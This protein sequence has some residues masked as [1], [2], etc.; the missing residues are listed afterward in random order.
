[1]PKA[2]NKNFV[3]FVATAKAVAL[4]RGL[5]WHMRTDE[6]GTVNPED[7]WDFEILLG[8][9][10]TFKGKLRQL[11]PWPAA[12]ELMQHNCRG[13]YQNAAQP[14]LLEIETEWHD[15]IKAVAVD[16]VLIKKNHAKTLT[17][18]RI[19]PL[20]I[21]MACCKATEP[22]KINATQVRFALDVAK[23]LAKSHRICLETT[24][25]HVFDL[26]LL[27]DCVPL[28]PIALA[29]EKRSVNTA[30]FGGS[31]REPDEMRHRLEER[32]NAAKLPDERSYWES[33][34]IV[35]TEHPRTFT[36]AIRFAQH[37]L[38]ICQGLRVGES[39]TIPVDWRIERNY[40][41]YS[42]N[43][44]STYGGMDRSLSIRYFA[45]KSRGKREDSRV[46]YEATQPVP[47]IFEE[48]IEETMEFVLRLTGPLR[49]RLK[50]QT[51]TGRLL[52]E[53]A[54]GDLVPVSEIY[55]RLSGDL[56]LYDGV[57]NTDLERRYRET[58]NPTILHEL[59]LTQQRTEEKFRKYLTNFFFQFGTRSSGSGGKSFPARHAD[60]S[61]WTGPVTWIDAF[62][63]IGELEEAIR[64]AMRRK[65]PDTIP[66]ALSGGRSLYPHEQ[67][68]LVPKVPLTEE[69]NGNILDV[70]SYFAI[71]VVNPHDHRCAF[72]HRPMNIFSRYGRTEEDRELTLTKTHGTRHLINSELFRL[73]LADAIITKQFGRRSISQSGVYDH[74]SLAEDLNAI[75]LPEDVKA[76]TPPKA[77]EALKLIKSGRVTG[78]LVDD[79][80]RVQR[81]EGEDAAIDF[82]A[83]EADG[84][85]ATPYGYCINS[86]I[87]DACPTHLECFNGCC[88]LAKSENPEHQSN[89][90]QIERKLTKARDAVVNSPLTS[91][92]R[93]NQLREI[94]RKLANVMK[95]IA[96]A[97]GA[98]IFPDGSDLSDCILNNDD[99]TIQ[100][101]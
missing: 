60:G 49:A 99:Q 34:R 81:L 19:R 57:L 20:R 10:S 2:R 30:S 42:G 97:P 54:P 17:D 3:Q 63:Q 64:K 94:D 93:S 11:G 12:I 50:A 37:K 22:W 86:F 52:P 27:G 78:P 87:I 4:Q 26:N 43:R 51:E 62:A 28:L 48:I 98:K 90:L 72:G 74:R 58:F 1:M 40:I 88:H 69:R 18:R 91:I 29:G 71:G 73:G 38:R 55:P 67:L 15:L 79:F 7:I 75:E 56:R 6:F 33:V 16:W 85:H 84:F 44:P 83:V 25:S 80:K 70:N 24:V 21:L 95:G 46:L 9:P 101:V 14:S 61:P 47:T 45:A 77:Q 23:R 96:V 65:L 53:Y 31:L 41:S 8:E 13:E 68:F 82:L 39:C 92:G 36:D 32:K 89:W 35:F 66:H 76:R 5:D 59:S 100:D